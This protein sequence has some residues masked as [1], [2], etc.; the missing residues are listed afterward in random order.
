MKTAPSLSACIPP[1]DDWLTT[2]RANGYR[3]TDAR[4]ALVEIMATSHC[5]LSAQALFDLAQVTHPDLGMA[6]VYRTLEKLAAV[7]LVQRVHDSH[8]CRTYV[9]ATAL[10]GPGLVICQGC[11][12]CDVVDEETV[13]R[14]I[15]Q[16]QQQ[17]NYQIQQ[18]W[19]QL[20][21]LCAACQL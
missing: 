3:L 11:G 8:G 2:L 12:R 4:R 10:P 9:A 17:S 7:G 14:L 13:Q 19:L 20:R 16:F 15:Q 5:S 18:Y 21:G 1:I 6:T